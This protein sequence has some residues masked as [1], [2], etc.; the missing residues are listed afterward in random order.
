[1]GSTARQTGSSTIDFTAAD[2]TAQQ[3]TPRRSCT[4]YIR[5]LRRSTTGTGRTE[6][7]PWDADALLAHHD[8]TFPH[9]LPLLGYLYLLDLMS[10]PESLR[11]VLHSSKKL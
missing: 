5:V 6:K 1:M 10:Q 4:E 2:G 3:F 9:D 8:G 7:R 11:L